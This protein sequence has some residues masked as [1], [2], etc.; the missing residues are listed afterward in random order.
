[1][2]TGKQLL[3]IGR[4]GRTIIL[5]A[6]FWVTL[7]LHVLTYLILFI[8]FLISL[9]SNSVAAVWWLTPFY[10]IHLIASGIFLTATADSIQ[11]AIIFLKPSILA[12]FFMIIS[13]V[14]SIIA[15]YYYIIDL[16]LP[17]IT[18]IGSSL[19]SSQEKICNDERMEVWI[20]F[21]GAIILIILPITGF[22][23]ALWDTLRIVQ[24]TRAF[25]SLSGAAGIFG[26][27]QRM[28]GSNMDNDFETD[29][30]EDE[31]FGVDD[32]DTPDSYYKIGS[33]NPR[34][35]MNKHYNQK[36]SKNS[37]YTIKTGR[38]KPV[39]NL[40]FNPPRK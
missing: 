31:D 17:C 20:L 40:R 4:G 24:K 6:V 34:N 26:Q 2:N 21:I 27:N 39:K 15:G 9:S 35:L 14:F 30:F 13:V 38:T 11:P 19:S 7:L 5:S 23:A 28:G 32:F 3:G 29:E 25:S 10:W 37:K 16:W 36:K 1:M 22:I 12:S 33:K 18:N 8:F